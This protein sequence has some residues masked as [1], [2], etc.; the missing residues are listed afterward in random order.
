M[1]VE[2]CENAVPT[3]TNPCE[4]SE[5]SSNADNKTHFR[6][7]RFIMETGVK[8]GMHSVPVATACA[9]YHRFFQSANLRVYEPYLVAMSAMYLAGKVEEQHLRTR[10]IINVCHRYLHRGSEPLE[11]DSQF[12]ELRDSIV[13]CELLILRRL[14]F[15]VSFQ[16]PHKY[17]LHYLLSLKA[18]LNRH[19]WA[20]T[21]ICETAWALLKDSYHS[22]LCVRHPP[23]H[24][25][26]AVL[27]LALHSYGVEVPAG[28]VEWW[29]VF[30]EDITNSDIESIICELLQLYDMEA[31]CT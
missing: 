6:V 1:E 20:R 13:Q 24:L 16:Y 5:S 19:A 14:N 3:N 9:L 12:W 27:Y 8:L 7:C 30:C 26:L 10:D 22:P 28:A 23:Q 11:L 31:K 29:Q 18:L 21:P 17:L 25:A 4:A 2:P 15:H